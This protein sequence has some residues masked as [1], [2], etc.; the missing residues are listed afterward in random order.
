MFLFDEGFRLCSVGPM[1]G[2]TFLP[3]L[4]YV[5]PT[6]IKNSISQ[7]HQY[8]E[9]MRE[10]VQ[11][12]IAEHK[13]HLDPENPK[14]LIDSYLIE[15][16]KMNNNEEHKELFHGYEPDMQLQQIILDIFSAAVETTTLVTAIIAK[17]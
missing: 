8:R 16:E 7:L 10:F 5:F 11:T 3:F 13:E 1:A 4:K 14:D 17:I 15:T 9:E 6:Q 2:I 12:V